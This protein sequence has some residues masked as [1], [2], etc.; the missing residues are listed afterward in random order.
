MTTFFNY[1]NPELFG[2]SAYMPEFPVSSIVDNIILLL[3]LVEIGNSLH[4]GIGGGEGAGANTEFDTREFTIGARWNHAKAS[5]RRRAGA[6]VPSYSS[7]LSRAPTRWGARGLQAAGGDGRKSD[8]DL[9]IFGWKPKSEPDLPIAP[10]GTGEPASA[11]PD[12]PGGIELSP[13]LRAE[14]A[15]SRRL[16]GSS[17]GVCSDRKTGGSVDG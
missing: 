9:G 8:F 17:Q 1:E 10:D 7:I 4:R 2:I 14:L 3:S 13:Q 12:G 6:A 16:G 5:G 15:R 11:P